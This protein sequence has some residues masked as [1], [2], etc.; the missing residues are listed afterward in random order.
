ML[1]SSSQNPAASTRPPQSSRVRFW[2]GQS[3]P[4]CW[5]P[6]QRRRLEWQV[7]SQCLHQE[8]GQCGE[9]SWAG[10]QP[11]CLHWA[12]MQVTA[13]LG[14]A[15]DGWGGIKE[16]LAPGGLPLLGQVTSSHFTSWAWVSPNY[17]GMAAPSGVAVWGKV[18]CRRCLVPSR[19]CDYFGNC[20]SC[21]EATTT[22]WAWGKQDLSVLRIH[23]AKV[24]GEVVTPGT[25]LPGNTGGVFRHVIVQHLIQ[26]FHRSQSWG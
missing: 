6:E 16:A 17:T 10:S 21:S 26:Q 2:A 12:P 23:S 11:A 1:L 24:S 20:P 18:N 15:S 22:K 5:G 4:G 8:A 9:G 13:R 19:C 7:P 14:L 25:H 3:I